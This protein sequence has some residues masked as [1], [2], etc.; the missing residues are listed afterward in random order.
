MITADGDDEIVMINDVGTPATQ[1]TGTTTGDGR[2]V[3]KAI[4][5]GTE[6][7][8]ETGTKIMFDVGIEAI[9]ALGTNDGRFSNETTTAPGCE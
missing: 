7:Y 2:F 9:T 4:V 6:A 5:L 3:G 8:Y 1:L